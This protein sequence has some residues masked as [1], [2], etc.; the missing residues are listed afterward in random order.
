LPKARYAFRASMQR[1]TPALIVTPF[2]VLPISTSL[3]L[4]EVTA[5]T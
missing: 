5:A 2:T 3:L 1:V 4:V